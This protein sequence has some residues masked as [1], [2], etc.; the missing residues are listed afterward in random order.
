MAIVI[1]NDW[2]LKTGMDKQ[3]GKEYYVG[4]FV[5]NGV[6]N[7]LWGKARQR[8][9]D[10]D[11]LQQAQEFSFRIFGESANEFEFLDNETWEV[12]ANGRS[13]GSVQPEEASEGR[14]SEPAEA[15]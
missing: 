2:H 3:V 6:S 14:D 7:F 4:N 9:I 13:D 10:F 11:S 8:A 12:I 1:R 15:E 5:I